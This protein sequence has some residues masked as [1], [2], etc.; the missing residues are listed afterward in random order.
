[1]KFGKI[2]LLFSILGFL[3]FSAGE[4]YAR[5]AES[6]PIVNVDFPC[7]SGLGLGDCQPTT[8]IPS[9]L[10]NLYKFAVGIAG[11]LALG[12]IVAGGV[13]YTVSAGSGDKQREA[14]SM[15]TSALL[16][17]ALLLGSYLVLNTVNPQITTLK[18]PELENITAT[19]N[20]AAEG[21]QTTPNEC[22]DPSDK[23]F[24]SIPSYPRNTS[25][26]NCA[27]RKMIIKDSI[28]ISSDFDLFYDEGETIP[29]GATIWQY[30]YF[31]GQS[32]VLFNGLP[33]NVSQMAGSSHAQCLIYAYRKP[34]TPN[35]PKEE[36]VFIDLKP[37]LRLC[38]PRQQSFNV[39]QATCNDWTFEGVKIGD[40]PSAKD[41]RPV[42]VD[43]NFNWSDPAVRPT[44]TVN[45]ATT[46]DPVLFL[47][48]LSFAFAISLNNLQAA[49]QDTTLF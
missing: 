47:D 46:R 14:K 25:T 22:V 28:S 4:F 9:Y 19:S 8:D 30:P 12:M 40:P 3:F 35:T 27:Y 5:A 45:T 42:H 23:T 34:N 38:A 37:F 26:E 1:M 17:V 36:P 39:A 16:G 7:P 10:N 18:L 32:V 33:G 29:A 41:I 6:K 49:K 20:L 31:I 13:Y 24:N 44:R 15:I 48:N 43:A 11:L 21:V 2:I